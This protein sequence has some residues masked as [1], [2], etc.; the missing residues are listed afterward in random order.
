MFFLLARCY[1]GDKS[2][3]SSLPALTSVVAV[4]V[5][6]VDDVGVAAAIASTFGFVVVGGVLAEAIIIHWCRSVGCC[7]SL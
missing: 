1:R 4:V 7:A 2:P 6:V 5:V 3:C